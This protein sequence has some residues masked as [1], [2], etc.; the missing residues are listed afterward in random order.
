MNGIP[1]LNE[2]LGTIHI[3]PSFVSNQ[4][5]LTLLQTVL[6]LRREMLETEFLSTLR[7]YFTFY[8]YTFEHSACISC[9]NELDK[10]MNETFSISNFSNFN[11]TMIFVNHLGFPRIPVE[12][13]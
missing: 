10:I 2:G 9:F 8:Y 11:F 12:S 7:K 5:S 1:C 13:G 6:Q 4:K 3:I